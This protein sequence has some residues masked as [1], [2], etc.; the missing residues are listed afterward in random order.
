MLRFRGTFAH[1][2]DAKGRLSIPNRFRDVLREK[3]DDRL[4]IT[5]GINHECLVTFPMDRW[6]ETEEQVDNLPAGL[7]KDNFIRHFI[8]PAQDCAMDKMGRVLIPLQL[9]QE[10]GLN[11]E[12]MV[13]GAL[14]KFEIWDRAAWE[15]YY[16]NQATRD[17]ALELLDDQNIRF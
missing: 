12:V 17:K 13:V 5:K 7:A 4:V 8:S 16:E 15:A 9:R 6:L 1:N 11:R 2:I 10:V 14:G 3:N